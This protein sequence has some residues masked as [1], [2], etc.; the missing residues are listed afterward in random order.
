MDVDSVDE[1]KSGYMKALA[2]VSSNGHVFWSPIVKFH[3]TCDIDITLF[4]FDDQV[5]HL[6]LGSWAYDGF[7]VNLTN[8]S[9]SADL[10][11]YVING[12]WVLLKVESF[13]KVVYYPCCPEPFPDVRV[14]I[15]L[16]RRILYYTQN[17]VIPCVMLSVLTLLVF[18]VD[19]DS[20][21]KMNLG[22]TV[23]LAFSVFML[24][25]AE[26]MPATSTSVPVIGIYLT[27][28]MAMT[29]I[30][31]LLAVVV[32]NISSMDAQKH[33]AMHPIFVS[34]VIT[35]ASIVRY[36]L[37]HITSDDIIY[38][39]K[40]PQLIIPQYNNGP[41]IQM[42]YSQSK[43]TTETL[44]T[45]SS[46][47]DTS[48]NQEAHS[49]YKDALPSQVSNDPSHDLT[50]LEANVGC[51]DT[52]GG[53]TLQPVSPKALSGTHSGAMVDSSSKKEVSQ[54]TGSVRAEETGSVR[55]ETTSS[56]LQVHLNQIITSAEKSKSNQP[57]NT[58]TSAKTDQKEK[59][60][61]MN[62]G[63]TK[64]TNPG[65]GIPKTG[66]KP[67]MGQ[68]SPP[69][70]NKS[71]AKALYTEFHQATKEE[72][73]KEM[74]RI[75]ES[76][77]SA[78]PEMEEILRRLQSMLA[79]DEMRDRMKAG[80][81]KWRE[82]AEVI[83]RLFFCVTFLATFFTSIISLVIIPLSKRTPDGSKFLD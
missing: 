66:L 21:E 75:Q 79:R 38:G 30:S 43:D 33:I 6:K 41:Q 39:K 25:M 37:H 60:Q 71:P 58:N 18:W 17:I 36:R 19:P 62:K 5:C 72:P 23:L 31:V 2:M 34:C 16:R 9:H 1:N 14:I 63:C 68:P 48:Q 15:Y 80:A 3:S 24:L 11:N 10:T 74:L 20:G 51:H 4:P 82:A 64:G 81:R 70:S 59:K 32:A 55:A 52:S 28:V 73:S 12:E 77:E 42:T 65:M 76:K 47:N 69:S 53:S 50:D 44:M 54:E 22:M 57:L 27:C 8:R 67:S 45:N 61:E 40:A 83:D 7:Q 29:S 49:Q 56:S 78:I 35:L 26:N 46:S 13:L